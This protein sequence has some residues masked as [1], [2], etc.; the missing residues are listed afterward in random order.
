MGECIVGVLGVGL[1][2]CVQLYVRMSELNNV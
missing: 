2:V 1:I